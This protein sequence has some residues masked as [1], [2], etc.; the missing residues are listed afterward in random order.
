MPWEWRVCWHWQPRL[1]DPSYASPALGV[2]I[3]DKSGAALAWIVPSPIVIALRWPG[4]GTG[5]R[6][7]DTMPHDK[8]RAAA[9]KR[10]AETGEPYTTARRAVITEGQAAAGQIPPPRAGYALAM[11]G[12]IHDWLAELR[13]SDP[14][15]ALRVVQ[16]LVTLIDK[17]ASLGDP[18]VASAAGSWPWALMQA[19]DR[20]YRERVEQLTAV[21]RG[22]ADAAA[23]IKDI[24]DQVAVL[25]TAQAALEDQQQQIAQARRLLPGVIEARDRL[26]QATQRL[27]ARADAWR[28]RKE[29]L[30]ASYIAAS[31]SLRVR[32]TIAA[33]DLADDDG[34]RQD[35]ENSQAIS[36]ADARLA[37]ATAQMEQ[38]LGQQGGPAGLMELRPG[39]PLR[40][41]VRILFAVEPPGTAL[42]IAVLHGLDVV[43]DQF[44]EAVMASADMLR[45]IRA[46]Q[47]PEAAAHTYADTRSFLAEFYPGDG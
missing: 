22:E 27:Q 20:S 34:D 4:A 32:E 38:A 29:V 19:L 18:L 6:V 15:G 36:A 47:A 8:I 44:P 35:K 40:S 30:K 41:D 1:P 5:R 31:S 37:E 39:A 23:L 16:A 17:G 33:L 12:E 7:E 2:V 24:Q 14:P 3:E 13:G 46:G 26:G 21:R 28:V 10:M 43:E 9:R 11:S 45:R 42:L 25:E